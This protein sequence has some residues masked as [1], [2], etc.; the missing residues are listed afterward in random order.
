MTD[1]VDE[2]WQGKA[3]GL[4]QVLWEKCF[5]DATNI[6]KYMMNGRQGT[7]GVLIPNTSLKLLMMNCKDFKEEDHCYRQMGMKWECFLIEHQSATA[8]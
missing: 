8:N 3:K 6:E 2:G 1:K 5:I 4:L 7:C